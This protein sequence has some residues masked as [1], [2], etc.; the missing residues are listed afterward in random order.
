M[1]VTE[2][3]QFFLHKDFKTL[4]VYIDQVE[5]AQQENRRV[6]G[7]MN[8]HKLWEGGKQMAKT[9]VTRVHLKGHGSRP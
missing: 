2:V 3:L 6:G 4:Q 1:D 5:D 8:C 9:H 7:W